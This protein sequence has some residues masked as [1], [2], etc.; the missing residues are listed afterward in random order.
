MEESL[1]AACKYVTKDTAACAAPPPANEQ[2]TLL[3]KDLDAQ[4]KQFK[5]VMEQKSKLLAALS[6][7]GS[8]G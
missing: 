3:R 5:L 4:C 8:V 1:V 6:K 7:G 2:L